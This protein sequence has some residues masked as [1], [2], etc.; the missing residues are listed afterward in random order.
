MAF[1]TREGQGSLFQNDRKEKDGQP[2][3]TGKVRI[4]GV[5]YQLAGW[6][7]KAA[8]GVG[9]LSLSVKPDGQRTE[10]ATRTAAPSRAAQEF[11]DDIPF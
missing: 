5:L 3:Y 8:S 11:N 10:A 1:E 2:D 9:Y 6:K 7:R 4:A